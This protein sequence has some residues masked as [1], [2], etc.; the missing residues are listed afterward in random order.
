MTTFI[1]FSVKMKK[2]I[3]AAL[4]FNVLLICSVFSEEQYVI[5]IH[6]TATVRN[7]TGEILGGVRAEIN[8]QV[9]IVFHQQ[10][11]VTTVK[12][13]KFTCVNHTKDN[14]PLLQT[15]IPWAVSQLHQKEIKTE[16]RVVFREKRMNLYM[17]ETAVEGDSW[18]DLLKGMRFSDNDSENAKQIVAIRILTRIPIISPLKKVMDMESLGDRHPLLGQSVGSEPKITRSGERPWYVV[19]YG[20]NGSEYVYR[21]TRER[22]MDNAMTSWLLSLF[23]DR[24]TGLPVKAHGEIYDINNTVDINSILY[25]QIKMI[26]VAGHGSS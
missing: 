17:G 6:E 10:E 25:E 5:K 3:F 19:Y 13:D 18:D 7:N 9:T 2:H 23:I 20:D 14:V 8:A 4:F 21:T 12:L 1:L 24:N 22:S 11:E 26:R 15:P 16:Y